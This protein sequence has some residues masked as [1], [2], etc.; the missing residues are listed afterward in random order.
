VTVA[1]AIPIAVMAVAVASCG[2]D[3][4]R[5]AHATV[6]DSAGIR[7]V[8]N[9]APAWPADSGWHLSTA[10]RVAIGVVQGDPHYQLDGVTTAVRL[11]DGRI[12]VANRG[13]DELRYYDTT[14]KYLS[15]SGRKGGGP[16]EFK[17][18]SWMGRLAGD[19]VLVYDGSSNRLSVFDATGHFVRAATPPNS[20][21]LRLSRVVGAFGDGSVVMSTTMH[22][23]VGGK[24]PN[25]LIR[26]PTTYA[27][28]ALDG[29]LLDTIG[30][31]P[32]EAVF[33][34][35]SSS[36]GGKY[37]TIRT[38]RG[39]VYHTPVSAV[40]DSAFYYGSSDAYE[41]GIYDAGG[42][43]RRSIRRAQPN[44][45]VTD[46]VID[47]MKRAALEGQQERTGKPPTAEDRA[48]L[49]KRYAE[50]PMPETMPAYKSLVVDV[51]GDLWVQEFDVVPNR[52][53]T[54]W[55]VFDPGGQMLGTVT[56]PVRFTPYDIGTDY[57]L[58]MWRDDL[59]VEHVQLYT[60]VKP[61]P[62]VDGRQPIEVGGA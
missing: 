20:A 58:G 18:M 19:S 16:G 60:L 31:F 41:I 13:S 51:D 50:L 39:G 24:L 53:P 36:G 3:N 11:G 23:S 44:G 43:L 56:M 47:Q 5:V 10:P 40:H 9:S 46:E 21:Q 1:G 33:M 26:S 59:D 14:G 32:G 17:S 12:V 62:T 48:A 42:T 61:T 52:K 37:V 15:T 2:G 30:T 35:S 34:Q 7:I 25:G 6:R 29:T 38:Q 45:K 49:E 8:E 22:L 57:V 28:V 27:H 4:A 54:R 55:T